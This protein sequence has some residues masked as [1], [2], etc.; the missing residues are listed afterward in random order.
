MIKS[1]IKK[2]CRPR[3]SGALAKTGHGSTL[4]EGVTLGTWSTVGENCEIG[5]N[6]QFGSWAC[7]GDNVTIGDNVRLGTHTRVMSGSTIPEGADIPDDALVTPAGIKRGRCSGS[8]MNFYD[9]HVHVMHPA[10]G[11]YVIPVHQNELREDAI[12]YARD[13][14]EDFMWGRD[15][16]ILD[17]AVETPGAPAP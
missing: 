1:I 3:E 8:I 13:M 5:K 14:L 17:Y 11:R 10:S 4:G 15:D 9:G 2:I 6:V 12:E 7:V 16:R